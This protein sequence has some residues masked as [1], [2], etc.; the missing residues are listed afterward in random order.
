MNEKILNEKV[1]KKLNTKIPIQ[2]KANVN[3]FV[4]LYTL[5]IIIS[6]VI[7]YKI[8][9]IPI[10]EN[11]VYEFYMFSIM[12]SLFTFLILIYTLINK[13]ISLQWIDLFP[14]L[15][16]LGFSSSL[17]FTISFCFFGFSG[18][19]MTILSFIFNLPAI[20]FISCNIVDSFLNTKPKKNKELTVVINRIVQF[21][22]KHPDW[23]FSLTYGDVFYKVGNK[24]FDKNGIVFN[25]S[26]L[27]YDSLSSY[28]RETGISYNNLTNDD[29]EIIEMMS[30]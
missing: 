29:F 17:I 25:N 8:K 24:F 21:T 4:F 3:F 20:L 9:G 27:S 22:N 6:I 13:K 10:Y 1:L 15:G 23:Y 5:S 18:N 14:F 16:I 19:L 12:F 2:L 11:G 28:M 30:I 26:I 7:C